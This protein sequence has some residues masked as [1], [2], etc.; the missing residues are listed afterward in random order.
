M[1]IHYGQKPMQV[2]KVGNN[3]D[4]LALSLLAA[5]QGDTINHGYCYS[6]QRKGSNGFYAAGLLN[7]NKKDPLDKTNGVGHMAIL[8]VNESG[9]IAPSLSAYPNPFSGVFEVESSQNILKV[10][11]LDLM[12]KEILSLQPSTKKVEIDLT[13]QNPGMYLVQTETA[14]GYKTVKVVKN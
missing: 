5:H 6:L 13:G 14:K 7:I 10:L 3:G 1:E 8:E 11:V 2:L 9:E 12:G 4:S